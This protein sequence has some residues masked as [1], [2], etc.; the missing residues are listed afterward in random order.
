MPL[1]LG[2]MKNLPH[3]VQFSLIEHFPFGT[4]G[5]PNFIDTSISKIRCLKF[6]FSRTPTFETKSLLNTEDNTIIASKEAH[7]DS[8]M[9]AMSDTRLGVIAKFGDKHG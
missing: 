8:Q 3:T 7:K 4:H 6:L 2:D 1:F 9:I 5:R